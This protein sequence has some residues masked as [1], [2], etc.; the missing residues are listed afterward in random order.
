MK[1]I[2]HGRW[3]PYKP[4]KASGIFPA[5]VSYFRRE[6]DGQDW[7]DYIYR[8]DTDDNGRRRVTVR[9][10]LSSA[11][12]IKCAAIFQPAFSAYIIGPAVADV[13]KL[14]PINQH[15]FEVTGYTGSDNPQEYFGGRVFDPAA[16]A[17]RDRPPPPQPIDPEIAELK[18]TIENMQAEIAKLVRG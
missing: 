11:V 7:Y 17:I 5:W 9:D 16:L 3:V 10:F 8:E 4:S 15:V 1:I 13:T 6:S 14:C 12:S 18:K 2:N